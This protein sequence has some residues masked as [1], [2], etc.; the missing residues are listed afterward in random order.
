MGLA[1]VYEL[2]AVQMALELLDNFD[3]DLQVV[4]GMGIDQ[5]T[6][7]L[8]LIWALFNHLAVVFE[9]VPNEEFVEIRSCRVLFAILVNLDGKHLAEDQRVSKCV[10]YR[11]QSAQDHRQECIERS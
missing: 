7:L 3:S 6:D 2:I 10:L 5:L 11:R 8:S 4:S 1:G 9:E